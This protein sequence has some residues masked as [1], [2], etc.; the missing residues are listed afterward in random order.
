MVGLPDSLIIAF[1]LVATTWV[2]GAVVYRF[3]IGPEP[4]WLTLLL[5]TDSLWRNCV[6]FQNSDS[7][8]EGNSKS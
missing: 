7:A 3:E 4:V 2:I 6:F 1:C 5:G 8:Y